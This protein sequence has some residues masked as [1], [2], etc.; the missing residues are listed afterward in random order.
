MTCASRQGDVWW[1][2]MGTL[3]EG[4]EELRSVRLTLRLTPEEDRQ[5]RW[6]AKGAKRPRSTMVALLIAKAVVRV[7]NGGSLE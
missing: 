6:L 1:L 5:L 2:A 4:A 7:S 3:T